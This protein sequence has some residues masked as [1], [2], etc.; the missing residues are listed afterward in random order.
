MRTVGLL[1]SDK[2][3]TKA[4]SLTCVICGREYKTESSLQ[5]HVKDK[6][7]K[8]EKSTDRSKV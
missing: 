7:G 5:K 4:C 6:H 1:I 2:N 3:Q 8:N